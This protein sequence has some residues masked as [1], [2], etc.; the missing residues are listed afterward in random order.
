M[1]KV[2]LEKKVRRLEKEVA[3]AESWG[4]AWRVTAIMAIKAATMLASQK[5][6]AA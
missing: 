2:Q 1:N 4:D 3:V 5:Q 6:E